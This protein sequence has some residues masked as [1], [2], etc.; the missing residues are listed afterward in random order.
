M[1]NQ[2]HISGKVGFL[3]PDLIAIIGLFLILILLVITQLI[4]MHHISGAIRAT[5][6]LKALTHGWT[7]YA[8][9]NNDEL[10]REEWTGG[11]WLDLPIDERAE[12]DPY[13]IDQSG[14]VNESSVAS[15]PL[16][17]YLEKNPLVFRDPRDKSQGSWPLYNKGRPAPRVRS[18]AMNGYVSGKAWGE[19]LRVNPETGETYRQFKKLSD[20]TSSEKPG[21]EKTMIFISEHPGSIN[22]G[23]FYVEMLRG[24][25]TERVIDYPSSYH[26][27]AGTLSYADNHVELYKWKDPR[28]I[29]H[30]NFAR[31]IPL[32]NASPNNR[33]VRWLQDRTSW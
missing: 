24:N 12:V 33:D 16:W 18:F 15:S 22:D 1:K 20:I 7:D 26:G 5:S 3:F 21:P 27:G 32:N 9:D 10:V 6:Q 2:N 8:S 28:T 4:R 30:T 31:E 14:A 25:S 23:T 29:Q 17:L 13:Y 11:G 19:G